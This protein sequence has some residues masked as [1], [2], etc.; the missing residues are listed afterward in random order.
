MHEH[1]KI[2]CI[3]SHFW[4]V[5]WEH[6]KLLKYTTT[7]R[8]RNADVNGSKI[9]KVY[10]YWRM[11]C[12]VVLLLLLY[13]FC[14]RSN[15]LSDRVQKTSYMKE[16]PT[17]IT[18]DDRLGPCCCNNGFHFDF[19]FWRC[20]LDIDWFG[21]CKPRKIGSFFDFYL[22]DWLK[23]IDFLRKPFRYYAVATVVPT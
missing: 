17:P 23:G 8:A 20:Q 14:R 11:K 13:L 7:Y 10:C 22:S 5:L 21:F 3:T 12:S 16:K 1:K 6:G 4:F 9:V 18:F 15:W 19:R 2:N